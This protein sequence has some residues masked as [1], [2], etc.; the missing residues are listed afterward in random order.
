MSV[1]LFEAPLSSA[2]NRLATRGR[3][4]II[5][6]SFI[7]KKL[8]TNLHGVIWQNTLC[9]AAPLRET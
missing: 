6:D 2:S 7:R 8:F 5:H 1:G 9:S 3:R 4:R